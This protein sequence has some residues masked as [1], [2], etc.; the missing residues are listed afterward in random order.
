[1]AVFLSPVF[2]VAGQLF[3]NNG[4][5]LA[6]GKIFT[7]LAG[8]TTLVATYTTSLGNIAH[9]NPIVLDGAGRVPSGEIWLT[10]GITYKFVVEDAASNLIGTYDNL[11]G[12]NSN[13]VA[14]T[15]EQ[16]IQ[17]ATAGQTVFNLT[18]M[19]Y[20][21]GTNSLSVFV[22]GVNQY[23]PGAQYAYVETDQDTVTFV[24]GL[25]VG[26]SVK[27]TTSQL[28]SSG[29]VDAQQ[30]SYTAPFVGSVATNV[31]DKLAQSVSVFDFGVTDS[32]TPAQKTAALLLAVAASDQ[33]FVNSGIY[34]PVEITA[35]NKVLVM[36]ANV[37][38]RIPNGTVVSGDITGPAAFHVSGD[39]VSV[40]GS[41]T[42]D[43]NKANN[44]S[45]AFTTGNRK[46][47]VYVTGDNVKFFGEIY[48]LNA[49]WVG[50]SAEGGST[51]GTEIEGLYVQRLRIENADY[52]SVMIWSVTEWRIDQI[53][54]TGGVTGS[55][56]YGT[57]DQRIR[58]GTQLSNTSKCRNG[59]VGFINSDKHVTLTVENGADNISV[60]SALTGAGG[61]IQN[62]NQV[63]VQTWIAWDASLKNQAY[64]IAVIDASKVYIGTAMVADYDCD[65]SFAGSAFAIDGAVDTTIGAIAVSGSLATAA[66]SRDMIITG[67]QNL[68]IGQITLT[69]PV[70]TIEGFRFDYDPSYAPQENIVIGSLISTGHNTWDV[71]VDNATPIRIQYVN[72]NAV[73]DGGSKL[74]VYPRTSILVDGVTPPAA[75]TSLAQIYVN[76]P[77]GDLKIIFSDGT[78]K[79]IVTD[80]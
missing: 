36:D 71:S 55:W 76:G 20:Q 41:F 3:D 13:F 37:E 58:L 42:A 32:S 23:G 33:V 59:S 45:Y 19:Q 66:N 61:K 24:S 57:K 53:L 35:S 79:T 48:V 34:D 67:A 56:L 74:N 9:S 18:T 5:P 69:D 64:G 29:A 49:Y 78:I 47:L 72:A 77:D 21:P 39:N 25:H 73:F 11:T 6:G 50:F 16:E 70:G 60:E 7:Y 1:M 17:T 80:T 65:N 75:A 27:F 15:N 51:A 68:Y 52:Y 38:F 44:D 22:D 31:E 40:Q 12:I 54:A 46:G 30:V 14:F 2:G 4:N 8:T 62:V 10:D 28:N 63:S 26:A 43:G